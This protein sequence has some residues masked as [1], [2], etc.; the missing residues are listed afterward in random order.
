MSRRHPSRVL[1]GG[2]HA[3]LQVLGWVRGYSAVPVE[4]L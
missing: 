1:L 2:G 4:K 3:L